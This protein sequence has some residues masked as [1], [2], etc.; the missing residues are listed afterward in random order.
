[1]LSQSR[2][3]LDDEKRLL[4]YS[5][6]H[7]QEGLLFFYFSSVDQNSHMLWGQH[8]AELLDVYRNVDAAVGEVR[9]RK[10]GAEVMVISDHGFTSFDRSVDLNTWLQQQGLLISAR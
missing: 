3:V 1:F 6:E 10:P 5:I 2:L 9:W 8:D 7:F 4:D